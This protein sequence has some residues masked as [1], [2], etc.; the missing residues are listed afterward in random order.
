MDLMKLMRSLEELIFQVLTWLVV[1]PRQLWKIIVQPKP[2]M[3]HVRAE[4]AKPLEA[5]Y[6]NM[7]SPAIFLMLSVL[8]A[9]GAE[10]VLSVW[11]PRVDLPVTGYVFSNQKVLLAYRSAAFAVWPLTATVYLLLRQH[12]PIDPDTLR[13]PFSE[14]C[15]LAAPFA[16]ATTL[17][18]ALLMM[19]QQRLQ[20][21]A[22]GLLVLATAWYLVV[23]VRWMRDYLQC[24]RTSALF[25]TLLVLCIGMLINLSFGSLL[26][27]KHPRHGV[28]HASLSASG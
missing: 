19:F 28:P 17:G 12:R 8:L 11:L 5:R 20:V 18:I 10:I 7:I 24:G 3:A 13:S 16:I 21:V 14:Q 26:P 1:Y 6:A 2:S 22:I 23:Q 15:Y 4:I 25:A 9:H 27:V